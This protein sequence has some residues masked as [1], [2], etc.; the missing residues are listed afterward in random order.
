MPVGPKTFGRVF[1]A[2]GEPLDKGSEV[3]D[4]AAQLASRVGRKVIVILQS[5]NY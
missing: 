1:N 4:I 5:W 3:T 2:L